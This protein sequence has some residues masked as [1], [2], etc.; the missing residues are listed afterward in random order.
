MTKLNFSDLCARFLANLKAIT[1][2][3]KKSSGMVRATNT[4]HAK[5][6]MNDSFVRGIWQLVPNREMYP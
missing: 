6:Q 1:T 3:D 5:Y 4:H 2:K